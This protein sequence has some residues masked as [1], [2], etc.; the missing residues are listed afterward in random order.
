MH[1]VQ[2]NRKPLNQ[3]IA[4]L[5]SAQILYESQSQSAQILQNL[6]NFIRVFLF[7]NKNQ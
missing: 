6:H 1:K 4:L 5:T 2:I 3:A 7:F